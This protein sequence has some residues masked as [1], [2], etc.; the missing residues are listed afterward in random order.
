MTPTKNES[1]P[2]P[3]TASMCPGPDYAKGW[4]DCLASLTREAP[5]EGDRLSAHSM[6]L[7]CT[8]VAKRF[9][10]DTEPSR[11]ACL[12]NAVEAAINLALS[13]AATPPA[14][15]RQSSNPSGLSSESAPLSSEQR[16]A[17]GEDVPDWALAK[18]F[19]EVSC[20]DAEFSASR[21]TAFKVKFSIW[22]RAKQLANGDGCGACGDACADRPNG[23][24]VA[25]HS[26]PTQPPHHDRGEVVG[27]R[28]QARKIIADTIGFEFGTGTLQQVN[29]HDMLYLAEAF[30][31]AL[32]E[33]KQHLPDEDEIAR[34]R[35]CEDRLREIKESK[36]KQQGP[37]EVLKPITESDP[38][39]GTY[40]PY[41]V[42]NEAADMVDIVG[43]S[44]R[45]WEQLH[46]G[47]G[48][49]PFTPSHYIRVY[50]ELLPAIAARTAPQVEAKR[51]TGEGE[52]RRPGIMDI[53]S[54]RVVFVDRH[55]DVCSDGFRNVWIAAAAKP[56]G[57]VDRG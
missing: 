9:T 15:Q 3:M 33:A 55:D 2:E 42:V 5:T 39:P 7:I 44:T 34:L 12:R 32:T 46:R 57:E 30:G 20:N 10:L 22:K 37:G 52:W 24:D 41:F 14:P 48:Q 53:E 1:L 25:E 45:G 11:R 29:D 6:D 19:R 40:G 47:G 21:D 31:R 27:V 50:E 51:Q 28:A 8:G 17:Q 54:D 18:A 13:M 35:R 56:S 16:L 49:L 36:A 38:K 4:N 43:R 26:P 23:C